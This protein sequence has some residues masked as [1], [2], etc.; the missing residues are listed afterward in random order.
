MYS[1]DRSRAGRIE[2]H[3]HYYYSNQWDHILIFFRYLTAD[4][5]IAFLVLVSIQLTQLG[6]LMTAFPLD[7][8]FSRVLLSSA[9][10][11][12]LVEILSILSMLYVSP[13]F[14]IPME[15][16]EAFNEVSMS[17]CFSL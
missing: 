3:I 14:Y 1:V 15:K 16:R 2:Y 7:P 8:R 11:G 17:F 5:R 4:Y 13:V 12:C 6:S 9:H 10:L